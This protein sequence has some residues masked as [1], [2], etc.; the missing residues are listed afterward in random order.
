[1][2]ALV[3]I[4]AIFFFLTSIAVIDS[5]LEKSHPMQNID[6]IEITTES[7][8]GLSNIY[9][10]VVLFSVYGT[11]ETTVYQNGFKL[12]STDTLVVCQC[13]T[14]EGKEFWLS[15]PT[16]IYSHEIEGRG[17]NYAIGYDSQYFSDPLR[18]V[19]RMR[20]F[21]TIAENVPAELKDTPVLQVIDGENIQ[22]APKA[23][24]T[25]YGISSQN[26]S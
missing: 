14:V 1:M 20:S 3:S 4:V 22:Y 6:E 26:N 9:A 8:Y 17:E 23:S 13:I 11:V 19:G 24:E 2:R 18:V 5:C 25:D 7:I 12:S 21:D 16:W 10:D 15:V